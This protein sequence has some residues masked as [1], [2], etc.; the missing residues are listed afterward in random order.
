MLVL[1]VRK[2]TLDESFLANAV[3]LLD[4]ALLREKL[5]SNQMSVSDGLP[6]ATVLVSVLLDLLRGKSAK[7]RRQRDKPTPNVQQSDLRPTVR[8][9]TFLMRQH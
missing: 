6:L 2:S 7:N 8:P 4:R 3:K 9:P 5:L 1:T